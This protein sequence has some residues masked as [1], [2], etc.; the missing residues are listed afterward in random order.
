MPIRFGL[1]KKGRL[2]NRFNLFAS[3][4]A[5]KIYHLLE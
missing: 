5:K 2:K 3:T 1:D 4:V